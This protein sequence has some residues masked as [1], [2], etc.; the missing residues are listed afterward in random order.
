MIFFIRKCFFDCW[1][2]YSQ[3]GSI[4]QTEAGIEG[5]YPEE[6]ERVFLY[7]GRQQGRPKVLSNGVTKEEEIWHSQ[8][9]LGKFLEENHGNGE[10]GSGSQSY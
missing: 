8:V 3:T 1:R 2:Q 4:E 7:Q 10:H 6:E 5:G 9:H